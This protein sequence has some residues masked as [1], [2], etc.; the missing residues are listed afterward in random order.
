MLRR[1]H[2]LA[3]LPL[4][5]MLLVIASTGVILSLEPAANQLSYPAVAPGTSVAVLADGV[6]ARHARI[7]F[8]PGARRRRSYGDLQ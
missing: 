1:L 6:A 7:E 8:D 5:L 4:A 2:S 3:G